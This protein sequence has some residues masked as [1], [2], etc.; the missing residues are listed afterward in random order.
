MHSLDKSVV[1]HF[2]E[3]AIKKEKKHDIHFSNNICNYAQNTLI[4]FVNSNVLVSP[5]I[6]LDKEKCCKT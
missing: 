4:N 6:G 3:T 1:E 5:G 2:T